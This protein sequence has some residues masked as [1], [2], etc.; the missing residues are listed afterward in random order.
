MKNFR[1]RALSIIICVAMILTLIPQTML[2]KA[3][4]AV[5]GEQSPEYRQEIIDALAGIVG[6]TE[7]A[8][9]YYRMLQ[10][11]GL[12]DEN[13]NILDSWYIEKDGRQISLDEI[14]KILAGDYDPQDVVWVDGAPVAL[15]DLK[16]MINIEDYLAYVKDTYFTDKVWTKEQTANA[17]SLVEQLEK[18][19]ILLRTASNDNAGHITGARDVSHDAR[20]TVTLDESSI[21]QNDV[22]AFTARFS[23]SLTGAV[24]GQQVTFKYKA[25]SGSRSV[26]DSG[27]VK[28]K[29]LTAD[30]NGTATGTIEVSAN[31]VDPMA[32]VDPVYSE[33]TYFILDCF[34]VK[35]ALFTDSNGTETEAL[36]ILVE[37]KGSTAP[38]T[39]PDF[40]SFNILGSTG[41]PDDAFF[42]PAGTFET[43]MITVSAPDGNG[44]IGK[45]IN[46]YGEH[47]PDLLKGD[48][49]DL[50]DG[51]QLLIKWGLVDNVD[52]NHLKGDDIKESYPVRQFDNIV[53][54]WD[55][56]SNSYKWYF[57]EGD[58]KPETTVEVHAAN[59]PDGVN[60][61]ICTNNVVTDVKKTDTSALGVT[62]VKT[63][64][65]TSMRLIQPATWE[66]I[67][68]KNGGSEDWYN[69][70]R[71]YRPDGSNLAGWDPENALPVGGRDLSVVSTGAAISKGDVI[72]SLT[73]DGGFAYYPLKIITYEQKL[74][75]SSTPDSSLPTSIQKKISKIH[76][77]QEGKPLNHSEWTMESS[78]VYNGDHYYITYK[79]GDINQV[80]DHHWTPDYYAEFLPG[81][82][83]GENTTQS[84]YAFYGNKFDI[85][86]QFSRSS[87]PQI[88]SISVPACEFKPGELIPITVKYSE[89]AKADARMKVNGEYLTPCESTAG[90]SSTAVHAV[91]ASGS[92]ASASNVQTFLFEV[93]ENGN[94]RITISEFTVENLDGKPF[95]NISDY[96][97]NLYGQKTLTLAPEGLRIDNNVRKNTFT[98]LTLKANNTNIAEP[99]LNVT[100]D[101]INDIDRTAWLAGDFVTE[102][103]DHFSKSLR[104]RIVSTD[105]YDSGYLRLKSVGDNIT[106]GKLTT[107]DIAIPENSSGATRYYIAEL[108]LDNGAVIPE[109]ATI[110]QLNSKYDPVV[111]KY[112]GQLIGIGTATV[113]AV[114]YVTASDLTTVLSVKES[115]GQTDYAYNDPNN[116]VIYVEK[117]PVIKASFTLADSGYTYGNPKKVTYI[118]SYGNPVNST[119]DF[120]WVSSD[121]SVAVIS[122]DGRISP[123][124][125]A[126]VTTISIIAYNGNVSKEENGVV[127]SKTVKKDVGTLKFETGNIPFFEVPN[128]GYEIIDG[129][130]LT[131]FWSTNICTENGTTP[132]EFTIRLYRTADETLASAGDPVYETTV[133]CT[134]SDPVMQYTVPADYLAYFYGENAVNSFVIT[135]GTVYRGT[136]YSGKAV[137]SVESLP[138]KV[139]LMGLD[140]YYILDT[141]GNVNIGWTVENFAKYS[142]S[143]PEQLFEMSIVR[144]GAEICR[145]NDPGTEY[146]QGNYRGTYTLENIGFNGTGAGKNGYR[147]IYTVSVK[148]KN[149]SSG[150]WSY[151]SF[152]LYVYDEAALK[153]WI[154]PTA[155]DTEKKGKATGTVIPDGGSKESKLK[156][157]NGSVI[158]RMSQAEILALKG[159][160]SLRN[161]ISAN[162]GDYAWTE[163]SDQL[164]WASDNNAAV[165]I[166]YRQ[167]SLYEDIRKLSYDSY[168][169]GT[170]LLL[171]GIRDTDKPVTVTAEHVLTG[172][173]DSLEVSVKT[174]KNR[175]YLFRC[176]PQT[177]TTLTYYDKVGKRHD[178]ESNVNGEAAIYE[179]DGI[180][181]D[182]YCRSVIDEGLPTQE[183]YLATIH[184]S[185]LKT[186]EG[187]STKLELYPY[188]L[189]TLRRAAYAYVYLKNPDGTPY[190]GSVILRGA[191]YVND[192]IVKG[193]VLSRSNGSD[194]S[195]IEG[196]K[197]FS[198]LENPEVFG[199]DTIYFKGAQF[200]TTAYGDLGGSTMGYYYEYSYGYEDKYLEPYMPDGALKITMDVS[201]WELKDSEGNPRALSGLDKVKYVFTISAADSSTH[202][203]KIG[204]YPIFLEIDANATED[205]YVKSGDSIVTFRQNKKNTKHPFI[206]SQKTIACSNGHT[207]NVID[208]TGRIGV[209]DSNPDGSVLETIVMWWGESKEDA[210]SNI[211]N[212]QLYTADGKM[213]AY[214]YNTS[215]CSTYDWIFTRDVFTKYDVTLTPD[216]I[217]SCIDQGQKK[218]LYLEYMRSYSEPITRREDLPFA[219]A[220][221]IG[222][223]KTE[224][225]RDLASA[226]RNAGKSVGSDS[227]SATEA[228]DQGDE[229]V[230]PALRLLANMEFTDS[231]DALLSMNI[232]PTNDP[233]KFLGLMSFS[234]STMDDNEIQNGVEMN[235]LPGEGSDF[236]YTPGIQDLPWG[237]GKKWLN[238]QKA[239][240]AEAMDNI[241]KSDVDVTYEIG[242][243]MET[244]IYWDFD[245]E[246]WA[247][248]VLDGGFNAGGGLGFKWDWNMWVGPVPITMEVELGG[249][250]R[251][252]MDAITT[253]YQNNTT[254]T[255]DLANEYLTKLRLYLYIKVFAGVGIDY[256]VIALKLGIFGQISLDMTFEWLNRPYL[257]EHR[258][259]E[260]VK[261][262][263]PNYGTFFDPNING[264]RFRIDGLIGI[265]F[266]ASVACVEYE[267]VLYSVGFNMMDQKEGKYNDIESLWERNQKN[268]RYAIDALTQTGSMQV[269][270][271]GGESLLTLDLAPR[272]ESRDYLNNTATKRTWCDGS[273]GAVVKTAKVTSSN[274]LRNIETNTYPYAN[275]RI[276][277]GGDK[278]IYLSDMDS[279]DINATRAVYATR[280]DVDI[281]EGENGA[282]K[283]LYNETQSGEAGFGDTQ[284]DT[285]Y[286]GS[287]TVAAW[288]RRMVDNGKTAG[289]TLSNVDQMVSLN[290]TEIYASVINGTGVP[291]TTRLTDNTGADVA[292]TTAVR[293]GNAMVAW[294]SVA[295]DENTTGTIN[296]SNFNKKD[297][298]KCRFYDGSAWSNDTYTVYNGSS[299]NVKGLDSAMLTDGTAAIAYTLDTDG[300]DTTTTDREIV[301]AVI[302][303][304]GTVL[305]N[306]RVTNND[307]L[308]ENPSVEAVTVGTG[309]EFVLGWY[310][311]K[312]VAQASGSAKSSSADICMVDFNSDGEVVGKIPGSL[313]QTAGGSGVNVTSN[314]RFVGGGHAIDKLGIAWV[315]RAETLP[316]DTSGKAADTIVTTASAPEYD[317]LKAVMFYNNTQNNSIGVTSAINVAEMP[318]GTLIDS[319]DTV[320]GSGAGE[321][322]IEAVILGTTYGSNG[323]VTKNGI[324]TNGEPIAYS[325]PSAVSNLYR[326]T[327]NIE[328][329]L[330]VTS[331][332]FDR[333]MVKTNSSLSVQYALRNDGI[334]RINNISITVGNVDTSYNNI[335]L[336]PGGVLVLRA[337]YNTGSALTD[338][339]WTVAAEFNKGGGTETKEV[340]GKLQLDYPDIE[341]TSAKI[342]EEKGGKRKILI[343]LNNASDALLYK[344]VGNSRNRQVG[345]SFYTDATLENEISGIN[346]FIIDDRDK[347]EMI[348]KGG[349]CELVE[350]DV[351]KYLQGQGVTTI[352]EAG[353][354][355]YVAANVL[356]RN[357]V[358]RNYES[359]PEP[360][361]SNNSAMVSCD[362]LQ[363]RT[364]KPVVITNDM[365]IRNGQTI[366]TVDI[367][368]T[369]LAS[370]MTGNLI[371][372]LM[373][374]AHEIIDQKQSYTGNSTHTGMNAGAAVVKTGYVSSYGA[375]RMLTGGTNGLITLG[376]EQSTTETFIFDRPGYYVDVAY[377]NLILDSD[378]TEIGSISFS[379]LGINEKSFKADGSGRFVAEAKINK[380]EIGGDLITQVIASAKSPYST[381]KVTADNG[382][383]SQ[384]GNLINERFTLAKCD[385]GMGHQSMTVRPEP[386]ILIRKLTVTVT[387]DSGKTAEY[388]VNI[389]YVDPAQTEQEQDPGSNQVPSPGPSYPISGYI[390][391]EEP[392]PDKKQENKTEAA[393]GKA[394]A[395]QRKANKIKLDKKL[396]ITNKN[397]KLSFT[398]GKVKDAEFYELYIAY[399]GDSLSDADPIVVK[400]ATRF[401]TKKI[402]GKKV[403]QTKNLMFKVRAYKTVD[404]KKTELGESITLYAAGAKNK[405]YTNV[406]A[407]KL[408]KKNKSLAVGKTFKLKADIKLED[409]KKKMLF[410]SAADLRYES[411]DTS[412][413][414]VSASGKI[415]AV[416]KGTCYIR[417][418]ALNGVTA[419]IKITVE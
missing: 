157:D 76:T 37:C 220:N 123:T 317:I 411:T 72:T 408:N 339:D 16:A 46:L 196:K 379:E 270:R 406:A 78:I 252:S 233:T 269:N 394:P 68:R 214:D 330:T 193:H 178:V 48:T 186:G 344:G 138:A 267:K 191:V 184:N 322:K 198:T 337:D 173:K 265:E 195:E 27:V 234:Y 409:E 397:G 89:P 128:I 380:D 94:S 312:A 334:D 200:V 321:D 288:V 93:K 189:V 277:N 113:D 17:Q 414:K 162:Y 385:M 360:D 275:P 413:A 66:F 175:L 280:N 116:K 56:D 111:G 374:E 403:D 134:A 332:N 346:A 295:V 391:T 35:N 117:K 207:T 155:N 26:A 353:I 45:T 299:G 126:G 218:N 350:F 177:T 203:E 41:V 247:M 362:N 60:A 130:D 143:N 197:C 120:A 101:V 91:N 80:V 159:D 40:I 124:G 296:I 308:D 79:N 205:N 306:I 264:Q 315:E 225:S 131:V 345:I 294:R 249:T 174:L 335:N 188:N 129:Q 300:D 366:V 185:D 15:E 125:K 114:K 342:V 292:P 286:D 349:Y 6:G 95:G 400:D 316:A 34:D 99:K 396:G 222:V 290:G 52:F 151:D 363:A 347:L 291:V 84:F 12:I 281:Y 390:T 104:V 65:I 112:N 329:K 368:N 100:A 140:N 118:N 367:Q 272:A 311:S 133:T 137:A 63:L 149:G 257:E 53:S 243:Y 293:S 415:T 74:G 14:R 8:E 241:V 356:E 90:I 30:S 251:V 224:E 97:D 150:T 242:G 102:G 92:G 156:M 213:V 351:N 152:L 171:S 22:A 417:V 250:V 313:S 20:V 352:P 262:A 256:S 21:G 165:S 375:Y 340:R 230:G 215:K 199:S 42:R 5:S 399:Y 161:V 50:T 139:S 303:P 253:A 81:T 388:L 87:A 248:T 254:Q 180:W 43:K 119:A 38:G 103:T 216:S 365:E 355:I 238:G 273:A 36:G 1:R 55:D 336:M 381:V 268:L 201:Q 240:L 285:G 54:Y 389:T 318:E 377:T 204:Y 266:V 105:G 158:E 392:E 354:P 302:S 227:S 314:F 47:N 361:V 10:D 208:Y 85:T 31:R 82:I 384:T 328:N 67:V 132:T 61:R 404:G 331:V 18:E 83:E 333:S 146:G 235:L 23:V 412:V 166:N 261:L 327:E 209:S 181:G 164:A 244:L 160:I 167:G 387:A 279:A 28:E 348:D 319:F 69:Y 154:Q 395:A 190:T 179:E 71:G 4:A 383:S 192:K 325:V 210:D 221:L 419:K 141:A 183:E 3:G 258:D 182:V 106:G 370:T 310:S 231:E 194:L 232:T 135:I 77:I 301:Y 110:E 386:E 343:K 271:I 358:T 378:N 19:G 410:S 359:C 70:S 172:M 229:F 163:L 276:V 393:T 287:L 226:L 25:L 144:D 407:V 405:E 341:V 298:I 364:G 51:Q 402:G 33:K 324:T 376:G 309:E 24:Q 206:V 96:V 13:G 58:L 274:A 109:N 168:R 62:G 418:H 11:Y 323:V 169:P 307:K 147:Q 108:Y 32:D 64:D 371:V 202:E 416:G 320:I 382:T 107:G 73:F 170:D 217:K 57:G 187:D 145:I 88:E 398:W 278:I 2:E 239:D 297:T 236:G 115:D 98:S 212:L 304:N 373:N 148:A 127:V 255:F 49:R 282:G 223:G 75:A 338:A 39:I 153:I 136:P 401:S 122:A 228:H 369:S 7:K 29:T 284:L 260:V 283:V 305:R 237:G 211:Y 9:D 259:E 44:V 142:S 86:A 176:Y 246:K 357:A 263:A 245:N 121:T 289:Q 219:L 59:D 326:V 372:S